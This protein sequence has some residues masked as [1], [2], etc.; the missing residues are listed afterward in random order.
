[1]NKKQKFL[2]AVSKLQASMENIRSIAYSEEYK[3]L[4]DW[5]S[6]AYPFHHSID[7]MCEEIQ[8]WK[9]DMEVSV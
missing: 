1:M 4:G 2:D 8:E 6:S 9:E 7:D 3:E 5:L